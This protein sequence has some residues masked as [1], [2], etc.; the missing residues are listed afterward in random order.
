M[1]FMARLRGIITG[2]VI[3]NKEFLSIHTLVLRRMYPRVLWPAEQA[4]QHEKA[5]A[6]AHKMR[7]RR[8]KRPGIR[9]RSISR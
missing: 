5:R 7:Q 4:D 8:D 2:L 3:S 6:V 1:V 9:R